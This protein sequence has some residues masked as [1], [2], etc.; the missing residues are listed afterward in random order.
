MSQK[1]VNKISGVL[2]DVFSPVLRLADKQNKLLEDNDV[3]FFYLQV[4]EGDNEKLLKYRELF[5]ERL[6]LYKKIDKIFKDK[7]IEFIT[8]KSFLQFPFVDSD[9][10]ILVLDY[11]K[12]KKVL[13]DAG[14]R[15]KYNL[16]NLREPDKCVM[17]DGN[18]RVVCHLHENLSWNGIVTI[19]KDE[20]L[21]RSRTI[22]INGRDVK[23]PSSE[24]EVLINAAHAIFEN[25]HIKLSEVIAFYGLNGNLDWDYIMAMARRYEW[26]QGV[27]IYLS[28]LKLIFEYLGIK[29]EINEAV[30][31]QADFVDINVFPCFFKYKQLLTNVYHEKMFKLVRERKI[32][33]LLWQL[34]VYYIVGIFW[35]YYRSKAEFKNN[36]LKNE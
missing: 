9:I 36:L 26:G 20:V 35:K 4:S 17:Q 7:G 23:I 10:D 29:Q 1:E 30:L 12:S 31:G 16:S 33:D 5:N 24:D 21:K 13:K 18:L 19:N 6:G 3:L 25:Y 27:K 8:I 22:S 11:H 14:F 28:G 2:K 32:K 15:L 34:Y